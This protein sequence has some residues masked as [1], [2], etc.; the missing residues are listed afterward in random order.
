[1]E[2]TFDQDRVAD[3][4]KMIRLEYNMSCA[5]FATKIGLSSSSCV[6]F[7]EKGRNIPS[8]FFIFQ[9]AQ[10]FGISADWLLGLTDER[11]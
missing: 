6:V 3:R 8:A 11:R 9:I 10:T 5:E 2:K 4:I 7:W 1:M